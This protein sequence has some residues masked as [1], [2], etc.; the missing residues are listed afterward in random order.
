MEKKQKELQEL[1]DK[2]V[3]D[4]RSEL[5]DMNFSPSTISNEEKDE[6]EIYERL[7]KQVMMGGCGT[8]EVPS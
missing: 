7:Q 8:C 6:I 5:V 3:E 4:V 2:V 1:W